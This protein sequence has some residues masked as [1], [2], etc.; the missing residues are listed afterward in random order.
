MIIQEGKI[1]QEGR[2]SHLLSE[3]SDYKILQRIHD[4]YLR[5][6]EFYTEAKDKS[7]V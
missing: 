4:K 5:I 3:G 6:M 2:N 7:Q 1:P